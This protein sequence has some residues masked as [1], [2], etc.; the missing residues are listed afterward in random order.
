MSH[1]M[2]SYLFKARAVDQAKLIFISKLV[3]EGT[4][5]K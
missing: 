1:L 5:T 4:D 3:L 2:A